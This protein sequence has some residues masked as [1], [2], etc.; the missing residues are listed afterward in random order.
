MT[1]LGTKAWEVEW[2]DAAS[3]EYDDN[4]DADHDSAKRVC[5]VFKT[6]KLA[7]AYAKKILEQRKDFYDCV[8]VTPVEFSDVLECGVPATYQWEPCGEPEHFSLCDFQE[9]NR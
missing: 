6:Q 4:G 8:P 7:V 1:A 3:V 9:C 5:Q 2:V